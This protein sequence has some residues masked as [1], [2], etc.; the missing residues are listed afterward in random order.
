MQKLDPAFERVAL[1]LLARDGIGVV[2]KFHLDAANAYR[3]GYP[4]GTQILI[5]TADADG[6]AA[7]AIG[8]WG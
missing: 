2:W 6:D 3:S 4:R 7:A 5:A 1:D 8:E